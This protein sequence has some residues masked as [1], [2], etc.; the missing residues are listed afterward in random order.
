MDVLGLVLAVLGL[1]GQIYP[2]ESK[3]IGIGIKKYSIEVLSIIII[4]TMS[5]QHLLLFQALIISI[6]WLFIVIALTVFKQKKKNA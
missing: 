4:S 6:S 3:R 1:L 2:N 5:F